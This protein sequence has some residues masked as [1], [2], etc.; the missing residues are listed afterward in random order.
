M[1]KNIFDIE[2]RIDIE[3]E[4]TK[5]YC[6]L[7]F[8]VFYTDDYNEEY[9][10]IEY[11]NKNIFLNWKYRRTA[12]T[13]EQ[14]MDEY[15]INVQI[16]DNTLS[17]YKHNGFEKIPNSN[18]IKLKLGQELILNYLEIILN[19]IDKF[20]EKGEKLRGISKSF[21]PIIQN[22]NILLENIN[23]KK[24]RIDDKIIIVKRDVDIDSV[25]DTV[26]ENLQHAILEYRDFRNE[27]D[28]TRKKHILKVMDLHI[29]SNKNELKRLDDKLYNNIGYIV[30]NFG[31]NH[32]IKNEKIK[33]YTEEQL[34]KWY[35]KCFL[36]MLHAIRNT[37]INSIKRECEKFKT[38]GSDNNG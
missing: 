28:M 19:L 23:Y 2:R 4:F 30:N 21:L 11:I 38:K 1:R 36:L 15:G 27:N 22:I 31:V 24:E 29:E 7:H 12:L 17:R 26:S 13:V 6:E 18:I 35:D 14:L 32:I 37:E 20:I 16:C 25:L 3:I 33:A 34:I 10:F 8:N 9:T 5:I